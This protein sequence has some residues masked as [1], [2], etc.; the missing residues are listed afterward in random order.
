MVICHKQ[1]G[2]FWSKTS[3]LQNT[4]SIK[5]KKIKDVQTS[6]KNKMSIQIQIK[7]KESNILLWADLAPDKLIIIQ[8]FHVQQLNA[9]ACLEW[10]KPNLLSMIRNRRRNALRSHFSRTRCPNFE[11]HNKPRTIYKT[12]K[13]RKCWPSNNYK[14]SNCK[15]AVL[16]SASKKNCSQI[17]FMKTSKS[18]KRQ[19]PTPPQTSSCKA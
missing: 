11:L 19:H 17:C 10:A 7:L 12:T 4:I 18:F 14:C 8:T 13:G 2:S 6:F 16:S 9:L 5:N 15:N 3:K 1:I